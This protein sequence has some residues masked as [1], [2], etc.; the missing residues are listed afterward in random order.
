MGE[1]NL[2]FETGFLYGFWGRAMNKVWAAKPQNIFLLKNFVESFLV[3]RARFKSL[4]SKYFFPNW[5][6]DGTHH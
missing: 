6:I 4:H 1:C 2:I 5:A 3:F